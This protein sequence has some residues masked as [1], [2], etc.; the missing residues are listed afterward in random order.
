[1]E[2]LWLRLVQQVAGRFPDALFYRPTHHRQIALT[3]DDAPTPHDPNGSQTNLILGAIAEFNQRVPT[4]FQAQATFFIITE[5]IGP[6]AELIRQI[7]AAGHEIGNH[8]TQDCRHANLPIEQF[9]E[10]FLAADMTLKT[11]LGQSIRWYR[12]GQGLYNPAML[13]VLRQTPGYEPVMVE[14]SH[15]PFDTVDFLQTPA[16]TVEWLSNFIFPGAIWVLHGGT[17]AR[18]QN[19]AKALPELLWKLYQ[20]GYR[21]VTVSTLWDL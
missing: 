14:A 3:I 4:A 20:Q 17:P 12:P 18:S 1:M 21:A 19:T 9:R 5:H 7:P 16:Y 13:E 2:S 11:L 8:G 6:Q 10:Q 15:I